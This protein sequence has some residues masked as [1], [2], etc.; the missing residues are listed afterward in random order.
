MIQPLSPPQSI[1]LLLERAQALAGLSIGAL[2]Q[3][4]GQ[5]APERLNSHKGWLGDLL[6]MALGADALSRP[7]PDF[8][9]LGVELKTIP[10]NFQLKPLESTFITTIPLRTIHQES[11]ETSLVWKKLEK[12]LFIPILSESKN[13]SARQIASPMLWC[14]DPLEKDMLKQDWEE[15]VGLI[16]LGKLEEVSAKLGVALQ[17]RPKGA[18]ARS[19]CLAYNAKG[20][21]YYTLPRGFY[22]RSRF[23][24]ELLRRYYAS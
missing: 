22:L 6:E 14:P 16:A 17:V 23:T 12:V 2:A 18:N 7:E 10:I 1:D 3:S 8:M 24:Q 20:E 5:I 11:F 15:L 21:P 9:H 19:L 13:I 4:L